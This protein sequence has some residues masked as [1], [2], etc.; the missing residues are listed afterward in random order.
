MALAILMLVSGAFAQGVDS[1]KDEAGPA[2]SLLD[3]D[4]GPAPGGTK[5]SAKGG[6]TS[7]LLPQVPIPTEEGKSG[8]AGKTRT[9]PHGTHLVPELLPDGGWPSDTS[10]VPNGQTM[11]EHD[12]WMLGNDDLPV[13]SS[14]TW[15]WNGCWYTQQDVMMLLPSKPRR[16]VLAINEAIVPNADGDRVLSLPF[17]TTA[18]SGFRYEPGT[19]M[20][21]GRIFGRDGGNRDQMIEFTFM[22]LF[23]FSTSRTVVPIADHL[24]TTL[25]APGGVS[26]SGFPGFSDAV[27]Q[28]YAYASDLDSYEVNF[29]VRTR[30]GRDRMVMQPNGMWVR[31]GPPSR[32]YSFYAGFVYMSIDEQFRYESEGADPTINRGQLTVRTHNNMP[33]FQ[34]GGEMVEQYT[35]WKWGIRGR[36]GGL[37]N[38]AERR[39]RLISFLP[40]DDPDPVECDTST[41][42]QN[43]D[44]AG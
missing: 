39:S 36:M 31:Q 32:L 16:S 42:A 19:R 1:A 35:E 25:L 11:L 12:G 26:S 2:P 7:A 28:S 43:S 9:A 30:S 5:S 33:G 22:G 15:F 17:F 21:I 23:D 10:G 18:D 8:G 3:L 6:D 44:F 24:L 14:G 4:V 38:F 37:V 41:P 20:T 29:R 40:T 27:R 34:L 13:Y